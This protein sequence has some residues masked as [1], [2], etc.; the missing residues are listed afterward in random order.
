M[1]KRFVKH[2]RGVYMDS[3]LNR[4]SL[5]KSAMLGLTTFIAVPKAFAAACAVS[6]EPA[7]KKVA[8]NKERLDYVVNADDAKGN[9]KYKAGDN[10][11]NCKFYKADAGT[12]G[13]GKCPMMANKYV[14]ACG[15]CK[16]YA[17]KA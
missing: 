9:A 1:W 16:S 17:K 4:R 5:F 13:Y 12:P 3:K 6:P 15:W 10:C 2:C 11:A 8:K 7:G 14:S